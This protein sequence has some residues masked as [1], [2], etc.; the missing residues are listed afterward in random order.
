MASGVSKGTVLR[1]CGTWQL[2]HCNMQ[3]TQR[4]KHSLSANY[5]VECNL[6]SKVHREVWPRLHSFS[7]KLSQSL[8]KHHSSMLRFFECTRIKWVFCIT[9]EM[10][11]EMGE[12]WECRRRDGPG[13]CDR[14]WR[15]EGNISWDKYWEEETRAEE[16]REEE[17]NLLKETDDKGRKTAIGSMEQTN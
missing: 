2:L 14:L 10:G 4:R 3:H 5:P 11:R 7:I 15:T 9:W 8:W 17:N 6:I 16:R 1:Q 13:L 12:G